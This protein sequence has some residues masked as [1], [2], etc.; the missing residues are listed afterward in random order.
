M[1]RVL[2]MIPSGEVYDHDCV[3]WYNYA[4]VQA[5]L[6]HYHNIGDAFVFDSSLKLLNFEAL[7]VLKIRSATQA[8]ID[9]YNAEFDYC[10]LRGSNYIH[11]EMVWDNAVSVLERLKIPIL[12]FGIGAQ[13][14]ARGPLVLSEDTKR[15]LHIISHKSASIGVRGM[16]TA[17]VLW[18]L[19]IKNVRIIG[20]PTLFRNNDPDLRIDLPP[21]DEVKRVAFTLRREVSGAYARDIARYL[22][23][24]RQS[25]LSLADRYDLT[26]A[27]QGEIEEKKVV[28]GTPEQREQAI[29]QLIAQGWFTGP[30]DRLIDLY[31]T[32]L[33]YSD[34]VAD[35]EQLVRR[36]DLVLGYR[37]HGNLM[38]L[39]NRIPSIYF[40]Y[41]SR[42]SEFVDTLQIPSYDVFSGE[43]FDIEAYWD[44][45][46]FERFN[47]MYHQR[48]RDMRLFLDENAIDHKMIDRTANGTHH[49]APKA[50][51]EGVR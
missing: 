40:S 7:D 15:I 33:F 3:R 37:L 28:M 38:A 9:R 34:V 41:D 42:T 45:A 30:D 49:A 31:R 51:S 5:N 12:A 2:V 8:D 25:I 35:Y 47:L 18:N 39:A 20:C 6:E 43:P 17:E 29:S 16:Y 27:A 44:Q 1:A 21:L 14:P 23:V 24:Q 32:K 10:F 46:R 19:G 22:A 13:A 48:Y 36:E 11:G 4:N 50:V 26:I